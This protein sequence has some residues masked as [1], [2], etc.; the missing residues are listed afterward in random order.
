Q[1]KLWQF[2]MIA[3]I[4]S[5]I[6]SCIFSSQAELWWHKGKKATGPVV[7]ST[8]NQAPSPFLIGSAKVGD[9]LAL[10][11]LLNPKVEF[12]VAPQ[13]DACDL[14]P[15]PIDKAYIPKIPK[16]SSN[17]FLLTTESFEDWLNELKKDKTYKMEPSVRIKPD[18]ILLWKL[19]KQ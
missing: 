7:A 14:K 18:E 19:Q 13:C 6:V 15:Q 2:V 1:Q 9:L 11:H 5:G 12:L 10:S 4:S 3:L 8:I 17:V 16:S